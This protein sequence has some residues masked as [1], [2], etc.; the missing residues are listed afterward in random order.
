MRFSVFAPLAA[1][2]L[3]LADAAFPATIDSR[4]PEL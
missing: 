4:L 3:L 2:C 1:L